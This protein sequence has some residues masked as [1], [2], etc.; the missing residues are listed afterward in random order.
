MRSLFAVFL[1][2][3]V[4]LVAAEGLRILQIV[5]GFTNSHVLFNYRM[6]ETL[7][8]LGH[9]VEL[10]TQMEMGMVVAGVM[11]VP[12]GVRE[13][14]IPIHFTDTMKAEGLKVFQTMMFNKGD[15][16]DLWWTSQ[17]FKDMRIESCEQMLA[18]DPAEI[19]RFRKR[20]FDIAI[21]HFHDLCP[22][23]LAEKAGIKK[24]IWITH[25]TSV[26]DFAAVQ[27][28]LR[29]F[30]SYVPHPLSSY[31]DQME[32]V[33]RA[34]N[35]LWHLSTLDF[36]NLPQNLLY[37]EN[38]MYSKLVGPDK[39]DLW[40]LSSGVD[41]LFINGEAMLDFP[42][43]FPPGIVFMGEIGKGKK[44]T[45]KKLSTDFEALM[46]ESKKGAI[47][48]S[49]GT[50]SNTTNMPQHMLN[51]F[52]EAFAQ[53]PDYSILWRMEMDVPEAAKHKHIHILK[54]LP[55]KEL[56]NHPNTRLLIAH[57]GYNSFLEASQ[58]GIPVVLMPLFAD[59][60][61]NA[62]RAQRFGF[63]RT[64]DKLSLT[65]EKIVDA[66]SAI[67]NEPVYT[68]N[69]RKLASMLADKP[70]TE[71]YAI[72]EHRL[73]LAT[74]ESPHFAL[75]APQNINILE[76]Y[77]ADIA[78]A[79]AIVLQ[80][81]LEDVSEAAPGVER[82]RI[83]NYLQWI[84]RI[85][86]W[87]IQD[88]TSH[89]REFLLLSHG[90]PNR[91]MAT[92]S[93]ARSKYDCFFPISEELVTCRLCEKT[94]KKSKD[95][96]TAR[97]VR[98]MQYTRG[99]THVLSYSTFVEQQTVQKEKQEAK[100]RA[101][102]SRQLKLPFKRTV[103]TST[104]GIP[105]KKVEPAT[106][107]LRIEKVFKEWSEDGESTEK[108]D[109]A[110]AQFLCSAIL[111]ISLVESPGFINLLRKAQ[112]R[113]A[114]KSRTHFSR[115]VLPRILSLTVHFVDKVTFEP[116]YFIV[117][118]IPLRG[119]HSAENMADRLRDCMSTFSLERA[120]VFVMIRDGATS[121]IKMSS[122]LGIDS[123]H[124]FAHLLQLAVKDGLA[125]FPSAK[126]LVETMK[127]IVRKMRKSGRDKDEFKQCLIDCNLAERLLLPC[128][129]IR[130]SSMYNM[131]LRFQENQ[132]A[133]EIFLIDH[134]RYPHLTHSDWKLADDLIELLR[135]LSE[136]TEFVQRCKEASLSTVLPIVRI[137]QQRLST[138]PEENDSLS[139]A[140]RTILD[141]I[142]RRL[143]TMKSS[144]FYRKM[145]LATL[146]DP[147][148]KS[149]FFEVPEMKHDALLL[150]VESLAVSLCK[151][152]G[153]D[154]NETEVETDQ[155]GV[156]DSPITDPFSHFLSQEPVKL[157]SSPSPTI[158]DAKLK[159][160]Q[161]LDEYF[162]TPP[163]PQSDP[164]EFWASPASE[165]KFPLLRSLACCHFSAPATSAE[166]ERL[167]SAAGLTISD[168]RTNLLDETLAKLL[169][170]HTPLFGT[171]LVKEFTA[172]SGSSEF[173]QALRKLAKKSD[174]PA[175]RP[176]DRH[177]AADRYKTVTNR[178]VL[179]LRKSGLVLGIAL[180]PV[181]STKQAGHL[182]DFR[183]NWQLIGSDEWTLNVL[184]G[185][186]IPFAQMPPMQRHP[187][188][189]TG[190]SNPVLA[191]E[192]EELKQKGAIRKIA[193]SEVR[194][195]S[196]VFA[197]PKKIYDGSARPVVNLKPLNKYLEPRHFKMESI[198]N[199]RSLLTQGDFMIKIDMKDAFFGIPMAP[200]SQPY[201]SICFADNYYCFT[202]L[203]F[204]LSLAPYVY[205]KDM[206][207]VAAW[208]RS[209]GIRLIVYLDDWLFLEQS[210]TTLERLV[211]QLLALFEHLGMVVNTEKSDLQPTQ[212]I[213]FL[214]LRVCA[215]REF[216]SIPDNKIQR[217]Q[218]DCD[219]LLATDRCSIRRLSETLGRI[220]A[221]S[222]ACYYSALMSRR[223]QMALRAALAEAHNNYEASMSLS[224]ECL[225]DLR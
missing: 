116:K 93:S 224:S 79:F 126:S 164:Y 203:P 135:P 202:T 191:A 218:T 180:R 190:C 141:G 89:R 193:R 214:G 1:L 150:E 223:L 110:V 65:T 201:L 158:A 113:Y 186:T 74:L 147:R 12:E 75:K 17:E 85:S 174:I 13:I 163:N 117:G 30:P 152:A 11:T 92:T 10:W 57:G 46:T 156:E 55:Q 29:T 54:W 130:W 125:T 97:R 19:D 18:T 67:L 138:E 21:G 71:P 124:C 47:L 128:I 100:A 77:L 178:W 2:T 81:V 38:D 205:T 148:F 90:I 44:K 7:K 170:L 111:P 34:K 208:L 42:R 194:W 64:L 6:A 66:M 131:L 43:P 14:R 168:L 136:V 176:S 197:I 49:L 195:L 4:L 27:M 212:T 183:Q 118:V 160:K 5:P 219:R 172:R 209:Q 87:T 88:V 199:L 166:S 99:R 161:E 221:C 127:T 3:A 132:R 154:Q 35:L 188:S 184:S 187:P 122:I 144:T 102:N 108:M 123:G 62:R 109:R 155:I 225:E 103:D 94:L 142:T 28:G 151:K 96:C 153:S 76:F 146:L 211:P 120:K 182:A 137:L 217:I 45:Q 139:I 78:V 114:L 157:T 185:F 9:E 69:A 70:T 198:S 39:P 196:S 179:S 37:E 119:P 48:F 220:N 105:D 50:V 84:L 177:R 143:N 31:G 40:D 52:V 206:R 24:L 58:T 216:L 68:Q 171:S 60:F 134:S 36:V 215:K 51:C 149:A 115:K 22:L 25:G 73:K 192:I 15:A 207:T 169:F 86:S 112:P 82:P 16:Y 173:S 91:N 145:E 41:V 104:A 200:S 61:I 175:N 204:G 72:L 210:R 107:S 159:A 140:K 181:A 33:E 213:E 165:I 32:L 53:F 106:K 101:D 95:G 80:I 98:D 222:A 8:G 167:F 83:E 23:A 26:Y 20:R 121:M 133:V 129:D 59:Q 63:A 56:M 189:T 162:S